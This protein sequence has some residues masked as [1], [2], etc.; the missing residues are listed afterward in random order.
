ML[1]NI[2]FNFRAFCPICKKAMQVSLITKRNELHT[3]LAEHGD[4]KVMHP[5]SGEEG[6]HIWSL[7]DQDKTNLRNQL[8]KGL[9]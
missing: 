6:D 1:S 4:V 5:P 8:A 9:I 3:V 7:N 2:N